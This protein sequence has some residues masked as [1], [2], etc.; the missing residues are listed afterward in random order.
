MV[1]T[2]VQNSPNAAAIVTCLSDLHDQN[3]KKAWWD[4]TKNPECAMKQQ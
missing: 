1:L 3:E 4:E 2:H